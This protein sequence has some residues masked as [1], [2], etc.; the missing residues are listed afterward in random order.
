MTLRDIKEIL[1]LIKSKKGN[2]LDL[3]SSICIDFEKNMRHKNYLFSNSIDF[4][5]ELFKLESKIKKNLFS[6][7]IKQIGKSK[8]LNNFFI[9]VADDGFFI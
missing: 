5:Y 9:K 3:D 6:K 1:K 4:I 2:G 8:I 7:S